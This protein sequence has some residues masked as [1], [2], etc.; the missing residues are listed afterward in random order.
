MIDRS[1][2]L[3]RANHLVDK[4]FADA[5]EHHVDNMADKLQRLNHAVKS[6]SGK[7]IRKT[8]EILL[9]S[10]SAKLCCVVLSMEKNEQEALTPLA[11]FEIAEVLDPFSDPGEPVRSYP[12]IKSIRGDWRPICVFGPKRKTLQTL[13]S[14]LLTVKFGSH[15]LDYMGKGRGAEIA[16]DRITQ[17]IDDGIRYFVVADIASCFRSVKQEEIATRLGLPPAMVR[18]CL[19]I[20]EDVPVTLPSVLPTDTDPKAFSEA[21]RQGLP[22]GARSSNRVISLLLGPELR[23]LTLDDRIVLYGD[24]FAV[25]AVTRDEAEAFAKTLPELMK[26][27]PAG[28]FRL[29]CCTL[30]NASDGF[31]FLKY[32]FR[33]DHL[34]KRTRLRPSS[35]SYHR[36]AENVRSIIAENPYRDIYK[37]VMIYRQRWLG[38]FRRYKANESALGLLWQSAIADLPSSLYI[39]WQRGC[40][41]YRSAHIWPPGIKFAWM[42]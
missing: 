3:H 26:A 23:S 41:H 34:T 18:H 9:K 27:H 1:A 17:F 40:E 37:A 38:S 31:N 6:G 29:K 42:E 24:D 5:M 8:Q 13:A 7:R 21:V 35:I 20:G 11:L 28:P 16:A 4:A 22:Q 15:P 36:F 10:F 32:H 2:V 25:P 30:R 19:L 33:L 14:H 12:R 39:K